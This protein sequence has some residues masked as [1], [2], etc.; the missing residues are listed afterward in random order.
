M[1]RQGILPATHTA[2]LILPA[3][4]TTAQSPHHSQA[5]CL[6]AGPLQH[7]PHNPRMPHQY[8]QQSAEAARACNAP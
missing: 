6:L 3:L 2:R 7:N 1:H 5:S 4:W 8:S